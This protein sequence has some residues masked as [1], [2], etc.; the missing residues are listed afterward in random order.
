MTNVKA[1][2]VVALVL[3]VFGCSADQASDSGNTG[4]P[5]PENARAGDIRESETWK[6]GTVLTGAVSIAPGA[7]VTIAPGA[8][9]TCAQGAAIL[10]GGELVAKAAAK[11]ATISCAS[12]NG[13]V[14]AKG[15][16][17]DLEGVTLENPRTA[18]TTT[19]GALPSRFAQGSITLSLVPFG[20]GKGSKLTVDQ[21]K[22]TTPPKPTATEVSVSEIRGS[23]T[24]THLDYDAGPSEGIQ[25][26]DG[27]ELVIE[28]STLHGNGGLD[29]VAAYDAKKLV[30]RYTLLSGAHCGPHIQGVDSFEIDHVTS[31]KNT[32]GITLYKSGAGPHVVKDSNFS[33]G[34]AWLDFQGDHGPITMSGVYVQGTEIM[35]GGPAPTITKASAPV[36]NAKPR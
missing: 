12:W 25:A 10:I 28:D 27:G 17:F 29:M 16:K 4:D 35:K 33:G 15:G 7:V 34:A 24:A 32:Y 6:D 23:M 3:G 26:R 1:W 20:V 2:S 18:I 31:E 13:L 14:V 8:K 5:S 22:V 19:E 9:I 30:V 36:A 21:V 11:P